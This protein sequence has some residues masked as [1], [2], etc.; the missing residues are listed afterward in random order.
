M[1][2]RTNTERTYFMVTEMAETLYISCTSYY[3]SCGMLLNVKVL[4]VQVKYAFL[5]SVVLTYIHVAGPL[6]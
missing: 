1:P 5:Q 6:S 3:S 2:L 4:C